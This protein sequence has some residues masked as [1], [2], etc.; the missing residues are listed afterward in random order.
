[1]PSAQLSALGWLMSPS[2]QQLLSVF[3]TTA[4]SGKVD[5]TNAS[6]YFNSKN[7][8]APET[9]GLDLTSLEVLPTPLE[10][11]LT[12]VKN[13]FFIPPD[14]FRPCYSVQHW[15]LPPI[16]RLSVL[17]LHAQQ[18]LLKHFPVIHEPTFRIDTTPGCIAFAMCMLGGHEAGRKWWAGEEVIPKSAINIINSHGA[19]ESANGLQRLIDNTGPSRLIDEE[20]GQE[21][22]KPI[23]MGEKSEMLMRA[24]A[25][26]CKSVKDKCSV[27]QAL[28]LFQSNNFLSS[29]AT[30]RMVAG[31]SHGAVV[32]MARQAG[33]F[34]RDAEHAER[35]MSLTA[36]DVMQQVLFESVEMCFSY[37]FFPSYGA[38]KDDSE[39]IWRR[40]A[41]LEGRRRSA[42][43]IYMVDTVAHLDA[44]VPT[45]LSTKEL[46]HLPLPMPDH[47]WR[48]PT[49]SSWST[50]LKTHKCLTL[51]EALQELLSS[52]ANASPL[53]ELLDSPSLYGSHG[54][55][56]RLAMV[57]ALLRGIIEMLEGRAMR[58][59]KPS[60]LS[61]WMRLGDLQSDGNSVPANEAQVTLFK[62]AL[63]RWRKAW[64]QD[65]T[66][67]FA[68]AK[69][70]T[71]G[72]GMD[73]IDDGNVHWANVATA[74]EGKH[75]WPKELQQTLF[76]PLTASG[77]TP[78]SNDALPLYWLA[79]VLVTHAASNQR[80]PLRSVEGRM[81][82]PSRNGGY[83]AVGGGPE[84]PDFRAM[85]RFAKNF[86]TRGEK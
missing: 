82:A 62:K 66:C 23:V 50:A 61:Q 44:A 80:L 47:V 28:M 13:P 36:E 63:S 55:F 25:S 9:A 35:G 69:K 77:A 42:F 64:D 58:V 81:G 3:S 32:N 67:R 11:A 17:A 29:D 5:T 34:D 46:A 19:S 52:E 56:A 21:L 33:F 54:P 4:G 2:I 39:K 41:E 27:V 53:Q 7:V 14:M 65:P 6:D 57:L 43:V 1:M 45:L 83:T 31:V 59:A 72:N 18:N 76:T 73:S 68:S 10:K 74:T 38:E 71:S 79:H 49:A 70:S 84:M 48:A 86:V 12:D 24:F 37:P 60:S 20:D 85:L 78:L 8:T 22:V 15:S 16:A 26:R 75:E 40:W 30:T 51:D